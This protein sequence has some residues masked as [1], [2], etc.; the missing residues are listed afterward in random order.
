[1]QSGEILGLASVVLTGVLLV[2]VWLRTRP[3]NVAGA[4]KTLQDVSTVAETAFSAAEQFWRTGRLPRDERFNYA[5][6]LLEREFPSMQRDH[7]V[8]A[9]EA[10]VFWLKQA[11]NA[12]N[13]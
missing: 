3:D 11:T 9:L 7:L 6:G 12:D 2:V 10:A 4:I 1:M 5:L 8:A 13:G